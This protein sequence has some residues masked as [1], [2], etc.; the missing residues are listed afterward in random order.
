MKPSPKPDAAVTLIVAAAASA[1]LLALAM[2]GRIG[3]WNLSIS[4]AENSPLRA[5]LWRAKRMTQSSWTTPG[6]MGMSGK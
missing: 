6:R 3:C 2:P 1:A 5:K 4:I